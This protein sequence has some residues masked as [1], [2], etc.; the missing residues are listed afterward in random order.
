[1]LFK[2]PSLVRS[3]F[4]HKVNFF[5]VGRWMQFNKEIQLANPTT[6]PVFFLL[7]FLE[8]SHWGAQTALEF[9]IPCCSFP[10]AG[11][12]ALP[13][14]LGRRLWSYWLST[15][16]PFTS[17]QTSRRS[18]MGIAVK[19][20]ANVCVHAFWRLRVSWASAYRHCCFFAL[21]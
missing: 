21:I 12:A 8:T 20:P 3:L 4:S 11:V 17:R 18:Q 6:I 1:M 16:L 7:P 2:K 19:L 13:A 9:R 5:P 14:F 10:H 15:V